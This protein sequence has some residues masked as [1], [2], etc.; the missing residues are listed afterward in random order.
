VPE[1][2]DPFEGAPELPRIVAV[3]FLAVGHLYNFLAGG[4]TL[5]RGDRVV[6][7]GE[8]GVRIGKIEVEGLERLSADEVVATSGLKTGASFSVENL[9]AAGQRLVDSGLFAKVGYRT[10]TKGNLVTIV[11][12][13]EESKSSKS[14]VVFDNF[15][16]FTNDELVAAIRREVPSFDGTAPDSGKKNGGVSVARSASS[17]AA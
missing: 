12:L 3:S 9:D 8:A 10:N 13:V 17:Q 2:I 7:E 4:L 1:Q 5:R 15:V 14:P 6:V 11:F 16:W